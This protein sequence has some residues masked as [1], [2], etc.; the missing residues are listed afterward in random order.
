MVSFVAFFMISFNLCFAFSILAPIRLFTHAAPGDFNFGSSEKLNFFK[1]I[2][3]HSLVDIPVS[4]NIFTSASSR[5]WC[6]CK[7]TNQQL[8]DCSVKAVHYAC[9][10]L[11]IV[12]EEIPY[13]TLVLSP[14]FCRHYPGRVAMTSQL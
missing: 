12:F 11:P 6:S 7:F 4:I 14:N 1:A 2:K 13:R 5:L 10:L 3:S 9:L 8:F